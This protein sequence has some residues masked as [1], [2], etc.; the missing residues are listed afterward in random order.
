VRPNEGAAARDRSG[1][2]QL[3]GPTA[4]RKRALEAERRAL[5]ALR[6]NG[7]IGDD[8]FHAVEEEID[9]ADMNVEGRLERG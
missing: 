9:W 5:L 6:G 1:A 3:G 7:E 2:G 8:A 4:T